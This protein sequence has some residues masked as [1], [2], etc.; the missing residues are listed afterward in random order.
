MLSPV[1]VA[2][3][4]ALLV[5]RFQS[6]REFRDLSSC[7]C[8]LFALSFS[9]ANSFLVICFGLVCVRETWYPII[10]CE[11]YATL[12]YYYL[13]MSSTLLVCEFMLISYVYFAHLPI[14]CILAHICLIFDAIV[15]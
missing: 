12:S 14:Y 5:S 1:A 11:T 6:G 7:E 13:C 10:W 8:V 3:L 15:V 9:L 4:F 2:T